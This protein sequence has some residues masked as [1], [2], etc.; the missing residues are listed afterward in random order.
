MEMITKEIKEL[1]KQFDIT[2]NTLEREFI[3]GKIVGL[4]LALQYNK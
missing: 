2:T 3:K 1:E 4:K